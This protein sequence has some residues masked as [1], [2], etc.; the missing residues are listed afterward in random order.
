VP[1]EKYTPSSEGPP[2]ARGVDSLP[3]EHSHSTVP[4]DMPPPPRRRGYRPVML[5]PP[6]PR[7]STRRQRVGRSVLLFLVLFA[8]LGLAAGLIA[9]SGNVPIPGLAGVRARPTATATATATPCAPVPLTPAIPPSLGSLQ[10]TTGLKNPAQRDYRPVNSVTQFAVGSKGY[11][12]F[13][14]LSA[15][16]GTAQVAV[17]T[18]GRRLM[19]SL[20]VPKGS[21]GQYVE[22]P[23]SFGSG[24]VGEGMV[25]ISWDGAVAGNQR[26][27]VQR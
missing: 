3:A 4:A 6:A 11:V 14:V 21:A 19:G 1:A 24:D 5:P 22:F 25:T 2:V 15:Q 18:P 12:T 13:K 27:T 16:A 20:P 9:R 26:F 10:L 23:V 8:V 17:C 7:G